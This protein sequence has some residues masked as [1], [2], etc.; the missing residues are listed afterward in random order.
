[1]RE[2]REGRVRGK[3]AEEVGASQET[4]STKR[5]GTTVAELYGKRSKPQGPERSQVSGRARYTSLGDWNR[6]L[7]GGRDS[8]QSLL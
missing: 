8:S 6:Y 2:E 7:G 4:K 5:T 1:M 3:R